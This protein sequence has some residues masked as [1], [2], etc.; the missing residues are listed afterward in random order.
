MMAKTSEPDQRSILVRFTKFASK[1]G[2]EKWITSGDG[3]S[4]IYSLPK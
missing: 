1:F 4:K 3:H 2:V